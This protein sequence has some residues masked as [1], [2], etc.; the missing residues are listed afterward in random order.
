[1]Y[2]HLIL[3][4]SDYSSEARIAF[5]R[6]YKDISDIVSFKEF[7]VMFREKYTTIKFS[8]HHIQTDEEDII[9]VPRYDEF[10]KDVEFFY[11]VEEFKEHLKNTK[12][13]TPKDIV[14]YI[15]TFGKY[16]QLQIQKLLYLI[17]VEY[18]KDYDK[19]LFSQCFEAWKLGPVN[20]DVYNYISMYGNR[21]I[22]LDDIQLEKMKLSLK[23]SNIEDEQKV[24]DCVTKVMKIYGSKTARQLVDIT[25]CSDG[26]WKIT[27]DKLG[28]NSTIEWETILDY[29]NKQKDL[30]GSSYLQSV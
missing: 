2:Q 8:F 25:H 16:S 10:F 18:A 21:K 15:L 1:M 29:A 28:L 24:I 26:P 20:R 9:S 17:Y 3:M 7:V 13:L 11:D 19:P 6:T 22:G 14:K 12:K 23:L 30:E 27:K 5:Y 4:C